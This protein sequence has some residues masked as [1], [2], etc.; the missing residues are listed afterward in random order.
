M[1]LDFNS[2]K[3]RSKLQ[4]PI[5]NKKLIFNFQFSIFNY[6]LSSSYFIVILEP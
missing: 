5:E 6:L 4:Y 3:N 2:L 1:I